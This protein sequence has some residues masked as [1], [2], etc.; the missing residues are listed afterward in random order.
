MNVGHVDS[1]YYRLSIKVWTRLL[2]VPADLDALNLE[3]INYSSSKTFQRGNWCSTRKCGAT[4]M[5]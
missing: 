1:K 5:F 4:K 3:N 2:L